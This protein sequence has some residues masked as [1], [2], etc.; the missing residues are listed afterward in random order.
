MISIFSRIPKK[1]EMDFILIGGLQRQQQ[2]ER[3]W[4]VYTKKILSPDWVWII[5]SQYITHT[6][7]S[8]ALTIVFLRQT[9]ANKLI[10]S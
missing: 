4:K 3:G 2:Q 6:R 1:I 10:V 8:K 5:Y 9:I 7:S